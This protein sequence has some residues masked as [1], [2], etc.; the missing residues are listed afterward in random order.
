MGGGGAAALAAGAAGGRIGPAPVRSLFLHVEEK[1]RL[2][3][4]KTSES[5]SNQQIKRAVHFA[6]A[7][8]LAFI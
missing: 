4:V 7:C 2:C 3:D 1:W 6:D 8:L 5:F